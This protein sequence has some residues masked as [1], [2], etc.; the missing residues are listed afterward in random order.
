MW[1]SYQDFL[2]KCLHQEATEEDACQL[3]KI[4][5]YLFLFGELVL[6]LEREQTCKLGAI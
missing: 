1:E 6:L 3:L 5:D 4:D 2:I